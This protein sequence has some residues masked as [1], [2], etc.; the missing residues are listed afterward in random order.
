MT[1]TTY[2]STEVHT[3]RNAHE[4]T[5]VANQLWASYAQNPT[6]QT[7]DQI[8]MQFERLAYS[9][10]N[11]YTRRGVQNEDLFQVARMG[12]VKAVDRFDPSTQHRF[13]TFATPTI[14]GEIKR[15][16]RDHSWNVHVPRGMQEL[17]QKSSATAATGERHTA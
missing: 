11:R 17:A 14:T 2:P 15:Y 13:T 4:D 7:R 5:Q 8:V 10:A 9:I 16:F 12:L 1:H 3:A 6:P